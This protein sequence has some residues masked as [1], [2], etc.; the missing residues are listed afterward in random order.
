MTNLNV[1][2][3]Y[4]FFIHLYSSFCMSWCFKAYFGH[5]CRFI[6]GEFKDQCITFGLH[7]DKFFRNY[8]IYMAVGKQKKNCRLL[9][10]HYTLVSLF[11]L[12]IYSLPLNVCNACF[13]EALNQKKADSN[14]KIWS[15]NVYRFFYYLSAKG[16][17]KI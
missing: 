17:C 14:I 12:H 8:I 10:Y 9:S 2:N 5:L 6:F 7:I 1:I 3:F 15:F 13:S 11:I 16:R 4:L